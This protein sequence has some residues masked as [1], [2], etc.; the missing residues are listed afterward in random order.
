M[1]VR[2]AAQQRGHFDHGWIQSA[3]SFSFADYHDPEHMGFRSLRVINEDH[4]APG[5]GFATHPHRDMEILTWVLSGAIAH[6]DSM[7]HRA[8]SGP[9]EIQAMSAGTGMAHSEYNANA[10]QPLHLLQIWILPHEQGLPPRY[11]Q[12]RCQ[13]ALLHNRL[14]LLAAPPNQASL[15]DIHQNARVWV[16]HLD[17]EHQLE[18]ALEPGRGAWI[19]VTRGAITLNQTR[20]ERGDGAAVTDEE[21]LQMTALDESELLLFDLL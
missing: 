6:Q 12:R 5:Q 16:S 9:G 21:R 4:I 20:L 15:V 8:I 3:H 17:A 11:Q 1:I 10:G 19:Q 18:H 2:R 13:A 7:G 14:F